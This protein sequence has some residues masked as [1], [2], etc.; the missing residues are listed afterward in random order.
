M[1]NWGQ[2]ANQNSIGWGQGAINNSISWGYQHRFSWSGD[3]DI[4]GG[5]VV[6]ETVSD[7]RDRVLADSGTFEATFCLFQFLTDTYNEAVYYNFIDRVNLDSGIYEADQCLQ[8]FLT[9]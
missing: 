7:F 2:G 9:I 4:L 3:T 1:S 8:D 5:I 6:L